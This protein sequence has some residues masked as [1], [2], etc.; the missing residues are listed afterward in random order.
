MAIL[1]FV[2]IFRNYFHHLLKTWCALSKCYPLYFV[3]VLLFFYS[4]Y[5][6][7]VRANSSIF[8]F[9]TGFDSYSYKPSGILFSSNVFILSSISVT[10][11][12]TYFSLSNL[13]SR[14]LFIFPLNLSK[15]VP[16]SNFLDSKQSTAPISGVSPI[17]YLFTVCSCTSY[18]LLWIL[19]TLLF[20]VFVY[21]TPPPWSGVGVVTSW[22]L[23]ELTVSL[24]LIICISRLYLFD[25]LIFVLFVV[26]LFSIRL[27]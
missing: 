26:G 19:F 16:I 27:Y 5:M 14:Y 15:Y 20:T 2:I 22:Y 24:E 23:L 12:I 9:R 18:V 10:A 1:W 25:S 8:F 13:L 6:Y 21:L 17:K 11:H 3:R 7:L 4:L